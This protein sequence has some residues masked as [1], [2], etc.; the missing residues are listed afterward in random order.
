L[1]GASP[2]AENL[3]R[4]DIE[5]QTVLIRGALRPLAQEKRVTMQVLLQATPE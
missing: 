4:I 2:H 1:A 3:A 5:A